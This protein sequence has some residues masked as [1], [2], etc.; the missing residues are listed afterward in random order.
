VASVWLAGLSL[1]LVLGGP[2]ALLWPALLAGI[3]WLV[4][5]V[6]SLVRGTAFLLAVALFGMLRAAGTEPGLQ[7]GPLTPLRG[8]VVTVLGRVV[9]AP[10]CSASSCL[11]VL[12]VEHLSSPDQVGSIHG[13]LQV[14]A[15]PSPDLT[16]GRTLEARGEIEPP[17]SSAGWPKVELLARRGIHEVMEYPR[18]RFGAVA[19]Q[20]PGG[21]LEGLR[22]SLERRLA[23]QIPGPEGKLAAGLLLGRDV[24][25]PPDVRDQLRA[26]GTSH[27][28]AVSG[29]NVAIVG[30]LT[31]ALAARLLARPW[32][33][34][35]SCAIVAAYTLL[36]GAPPSATRAGLMF[37]ATALATVVGRL[38]DAVTTL[39]LTGALMCAVDPLL[40]KDLGF[41]LSF[42][43]TAGLVLYG[44][45]LTPK[46]RLIP[47]DIA[48]VLGLT[49]SAEL[50]TLPLVVYVFHAMSLIAPIA[51]VLVAPLL[52]A[53]MGFSVLTLVASGWP[54][55]GEALAAAAWI[56]GHAILL[57][58]AWAAGLP[59]ATLA[60][61]SLP[62][63]A[64]LAAYLLI[65][66]PPG[67][68]L[69]AR[70]LR[71]PNTGL[72]GQVGMALAASGLVG[73]A[74]VAS[75]REPADGRLRVLFF[76]VSGDG[77][78]LLET[79]SGR[80]VLVGSANSPL[81]AAVLAEQLPLFDRSI[82]LLV[83]TRAGERDMDGLVEIVRRYP[84]G[85]VVQP[86][87]STSSG[88][89]RWTDYLAEKA[90]P[91]VAAS[92]GM[93]ID[94][95]GGIHLEVVDQ[96][97]APDR[98]SSLS[99]RVEFG[100]LDLRVVG[101]SSVGATDAGASLVIRLPPEVG[102][103][104]RL[105]TLVESASDR[106][107][108]VGGRSAPRGDAWPG[109]INLAN[110]DVFELS[111]DG[112]DTQLRRRRCAPGSDSCASPEINWGPP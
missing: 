73:V 80:R 52:P 102:P 38:P 62:V 37:D 3:G 6:G 4:A 86:E 64:L 98:A 28:L 67:L 12:H 56:L 16:F 97:D 42:A 22:A 33:V 81:A 27:I 104:Q 25:L 53:L 7:E 54:I 21:Q 66:V 105:R 109:Q 8:Q 59:I 71:R 84:V 83:V 90:I 50:L 96:S 1:G 65:L 47:R 15:R 57:V 48:A 24:S 14:R 87:S 40:L 108:V 10:R 101:G 60:T 43:A 88:W 58:V 20:P 111:S 26:T 107:V 61:G 95:E 31:L 34:A 55:V 93:G 91:A 5:P 112:L 85:S 32:A 51:N 89:S 30:G 100:D 9:E 49:L 103:T 11:F 2:P 82:D 70:T 74:L 23:E 18:L 78:T 36:V 92:S 41:Q 13:L 35:L 94:L 75:L 99:I 69:L 72:W 77:L 39:L 76:D 45:R 110:G 79:P 19:D 106:G 68:E 44:T 63:W 17:R 46:W 29:F